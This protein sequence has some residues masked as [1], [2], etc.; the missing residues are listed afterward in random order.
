MKIYT[1]NNLPCQVCAWYTRLWHVHEWII[2][3]VAG[4]C[5]KGT[6][7]RRPYNPVISLLSP[8]EREV[9]NVMLA[10]YWRAI[11]LP[12]QTRPWTI[13]RTSR[14]MRKWAHYRRTQNVPRWFKW[15]FFCKYIFYSRKNKRLNTKKNTK[16]RKSNTLRI[17]SLKRWFDFFFHVKTLWVCW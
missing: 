15:L 11:Q 4:L 10:N 5:A 12:F 8:K 9:L 1:S 7:C 14:G 2:Q 13:T 6:Y 3:S 17:V 16:I